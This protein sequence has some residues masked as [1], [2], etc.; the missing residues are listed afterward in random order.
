VRATEDAQAPGAAHRRRERRTRHALLATT[1]HLWAELAANGRASLGLD[2][3]GTITVDRDH[4]ELAG[5]ADDDVAAAIATCASAG[6]V[7]SA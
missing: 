2:D 1:G 5:V 7:V 6:V 3:A 4:P